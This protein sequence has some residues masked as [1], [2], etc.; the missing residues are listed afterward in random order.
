MTPWSVQG[1]VERLREAKAV[2]RR[3]A[4]VRE[5]SLWAGLVLLRGAAASRALA[6]YYR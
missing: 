3:A 5:P 2:D 6:A 4:G 1:S